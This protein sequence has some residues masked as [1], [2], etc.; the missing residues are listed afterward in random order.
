[1]TQPALWHVM[2]LISIYV[3]IATGFPTRWQQSVDCTKK[4]EKDSTKGE[5]IQKQR[6]HK[7]KK[8]KTKNKQ[9]EYYKP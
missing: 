8:F 2:V 9:K 5:K 4:L 1:M 7:I 3:F 6:I